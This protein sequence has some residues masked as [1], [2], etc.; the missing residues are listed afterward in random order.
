[1]KG[2]EQDQGDSDADLHP[3]HAF[4]CMKCSHYAQL[5]PVL[6]EISAGNPGQLTDSPG[7][8]KQGT[9]TGRHH[10]CGCRASLP[11]QFVSRGEGACTCI[12]PS[13]STRA[14]L[15]HDNGNDQPVGHESYHI[16]E[17]HTSVPISPRFLGRVCRASGIRFLYSRLRPHWPVAATGLPS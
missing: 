14:I 11:L 1:E 13:C 6:N 2:Q 3:G 4:I 12:C 8:V 17:R 9:H 5:P 16:K 7:A 10:R 15:V